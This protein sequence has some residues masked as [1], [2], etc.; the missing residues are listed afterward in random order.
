MAESL[1][2]NE[3][4]KSGPARPKFAEQMRLEWRDRSLGAG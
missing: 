3:F 2:H 1:N 4:D